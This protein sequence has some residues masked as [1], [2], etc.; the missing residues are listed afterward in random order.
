MAEQ[1]C[2]MAE[3]R[4]AAAS[5][6]SSSASSSSSTHMSLDDGDLDS[7]VKSARVSDD[8]SCAMSLDDDVSISRILKLKSK[9]DVFFEVS[10]KVAEMSELIKTAATQG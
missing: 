7:S 2:S 4:A 5:S 9:G 1:K 8:G 3:Q 10:L 6:S